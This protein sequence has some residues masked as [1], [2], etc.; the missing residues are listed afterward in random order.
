MPYFEGSNISSI[1]ENDE[2]P[3]MKPESFI[4]DNC[5]EPTAEYELVNVGTEHWCQACIDDLAEDETEE[6]GYDFDAENED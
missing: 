1:P 4:C 3:R 5:E 6:W 2:E